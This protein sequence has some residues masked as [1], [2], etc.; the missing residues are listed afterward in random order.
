[1]AIV[2]VIWVGIGP[3]AGSLALALHTLAALAK[4]Y[5]EQVESILPGPLEAVTGHRSKPAANDRL[6]SRSSDRFPL[7]LLYHVPLG[8]QCPHVNHHRFCGRRRYRLPASAK[9]QP[10]GLPGGQCS[11][12]G[13]CC[14]SGLN[15]LRQFRGPG[16]YGLRSKFS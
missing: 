2:F 11:D 1:M 5:S 16:T 6:C 8:Y 12:A 14:G 4:L 10:A 13:H 7:Y 3:F 15:G 9:Y